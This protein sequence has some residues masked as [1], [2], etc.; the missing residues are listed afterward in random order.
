MGDRYEFKLQCLN[1][2]WPVWCYY[3]ESCSSTKTKCSHCGREFRIVMDFKLVEIGTKK[4]SR[5]K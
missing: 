5:K 1:C 4:K 2:S 3:A